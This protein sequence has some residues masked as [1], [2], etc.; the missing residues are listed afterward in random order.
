M[1]N[2]EEYERLCAEWQ[3]T[4]NS[5]LIKDGSVNWGKYTNSKPR[6]LWILTEELD[7]PNLTEYFRQLGN[8]NPQYNNWQ[9]SYGIF[10]KTSYGILN[11]MM[12]WKA[13]SNIDVVDV[14]KKAGAI[15]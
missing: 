8:K 12:D 11:G 6:L 7:L 5:R 15:F 2:K 13:F 1:V 10:V 3:N 4:Y 9:A 14:L